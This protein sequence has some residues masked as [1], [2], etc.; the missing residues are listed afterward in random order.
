[1][2]KGNGKG[3]GASAGSGNGRRPEVLG[4]DESLENW[5]ALP[6]VEGLL[7][8]RL[9]LPATEE[10]IRKEMTGPALPRATLHPLFVFQSPRFPRTIQVDPTGRPHV[11]MTP[12]HCADAAEHS[13]GLPKSAR[14][15]PHALLVLFDFLSEKDLETRRYFYRRICD[16]MR[17]RN[18]VVAA[19]EAGAADR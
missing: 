11:V 3:N 4:L 14:L 19:L 9:V 2:G 6:Q 1:M 18:G 8:G 16:A 5:I 12:V 15:H 17:I 10:A 13:Y 7:V